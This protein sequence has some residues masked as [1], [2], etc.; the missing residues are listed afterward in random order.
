MINTHSERKAASLTGE[1]QGALPI[2]IRAPVHGPEF[3]TGF[4]RAKLYELASRGKIRSV[5]I[6]EAGKLKGV[7]LFELASI[8]RFIEAIEA[9]MEKAVNPDRQ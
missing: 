7:R 5:S 2:W 6:R 3:F 8:L 9:E 4:T 1:R